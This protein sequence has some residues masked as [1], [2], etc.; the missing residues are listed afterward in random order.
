MIIQNHSDFVT[1]L[2]EAGFT[3]G[4]R[5]ADGNYA[6]YPYSGDERTI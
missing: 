2:I 3:I 1:V 6:V 5:N 4:V